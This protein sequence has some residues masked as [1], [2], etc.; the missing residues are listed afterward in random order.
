[1][2][3]KYLKFTNKTAATVKIKE[4]EELLGI[5]D[6]KGTEN[7]CDPIKEGS[8]WVVPLKQHGSWK[9][10]HLVEASDVVTG[11]LTPPDGE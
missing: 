6:G 9:T 5:P 8:A 4:L 1:M 10:I 3:M 11:E 7:Y 2:D